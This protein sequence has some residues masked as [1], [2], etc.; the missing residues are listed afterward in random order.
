M[1]ALDSLEFAIAQKRVDDYALEAPRPDPQAIER[2]ECEGFLHRG[3]DA[4]KWLLRAEEVVREAAYEGIIPFAPQAEEALQSLYQSWLSPC[5]MA[6]AWISKLAETGHAP[7]SVD[8]F[9]KCCQHV[10]GWLEQRDWLKRSRQS[11]EKRLAEEAW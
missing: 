2:R 5:E 10:R 9:R 8:E 7:A 4:C 11:L 1:V 3:I 6:E